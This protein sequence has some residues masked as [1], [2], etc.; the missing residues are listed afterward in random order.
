VGSA[1][2]GFNLLMTAGP[3]TSANPSLALPPAGGGLGATFED[4]AALAAFASVAGFAEGA[5]VGGVVGAAGGDW[6]DVV[7][8]EGDVVLGGLAADLAAVVVAFEDL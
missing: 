6:G 4:A 2:A 8:F 7:D 1:G 3:A 5:E